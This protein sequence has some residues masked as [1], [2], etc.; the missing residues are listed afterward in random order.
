MSRNAETDSDFVSNLNLDNF[1]PHINETELVMV[2]FWSPNCQPCHR[3]MPVFQRVAKNF[4]EINF[5][6]V[7]VEVEQELAAAL[8]IQSLPTVMI[9]Q[10]GELVYRAGKTHLASELE[11]LLSAVMD[12]KQSF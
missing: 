1:I 11:D 4:S 10:N 9:F 12:S 7:N 2:N 5:G 3:F 8:R 6:V